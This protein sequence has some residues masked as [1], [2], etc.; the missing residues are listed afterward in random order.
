MKLAKYVQHDRHYHK[1]QQQQRG[2]GVSHPLFSYHNHHHQRDPFPDGW[3]ARA[4][5]QHFFIRHWCIMGR[6]RRH[7]RG[8]ERD[9]RAN[10]IRARML[11]GVPLP[12]CRLRWM[13]L[14][15]GLADAVHASL[16]QGA[17]PG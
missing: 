3:A 10:G 8:L 17:Q 12:G 13:G 5:P 6:N 11:R 1:Q 14:P 16:G 2:R 7:G 9:V 4:V 15:A